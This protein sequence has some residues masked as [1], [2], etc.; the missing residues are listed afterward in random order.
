MF[1][2]IQTRLMFYLVPFSIVTT[3][4]LVAILIYGQYSLF[5]EELNKSLYR[6]SILAENTITKLCIANDKSLEDINFQFLND[7]PDIEYSIISKNRTI[8]GDAIP[9][10]Y[11]LDFNKDNIIQETYKNNLYYRTFIKKF[12]S[13][14]LSNYYLLL[15]VSD[16]KMTANKN[17]VI[18]LTTILL[19][20][21]YIFVWM[22]SKRITF[23]IQRPVKKLSTLAKDMAQGELNTE[24]KMDT[25]DE[26][27]DIANSF[28]SM[29][30]DLKSIMTEV[31]IKS[32]QTAEIS[33]I[34]GYVE[35]ALN[36]MPSG[37]IGVDNSGQI[38]VFNETA[39]RITSINSNDILGKNIANPMPVGIENLITPLK[40]CLLLGR[41]KLKTITEI[42]NPLKKKITV[43]YNTT[44]Q[45]DQN[46]KVIGALI[47]FKRIE[48]IERFEKSAEQ[49][50]SLRYLGEISASLAH[51]MR[52]PLTSI[53]GYT[54]YLQMML[55]DRKDLQEELN[56]ITNETDR[57]DVMLSNFLRFAKPDIPKKESSDLNALISYVL[58]FMKA[59]IP[60]NITIKEDYNEIPKVMID[61]S[62][63]E[64]VFINLFINAIHAMPDGGTLNIK[65]HYSNKRKMVIVE[66]SDTGIGIPQD[67]ADKIF[68]PFSTTKSDGTGL[69]LAICN[70]II[71]AH[72]GIIEVESQEGKGAKFT[73]LLRGS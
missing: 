23:A 44:I 29:Q 47:L 54:Q 16:A 42:Y 46:K 43:L 64:S 32:G 10:K 66:V 56:T 39:Q 53:K 15:E 8:L 51:E 35:N 49:N 55:T 67:F 9:S 14:Q 41:I 38:T 58:N 24:I 60:D 19:I 63:F 30:N 40:S 5:N 27:S 45:F 52:N 50:R 25:N 26:L 2:S 72:N 62:Q 6:H 73:I 12:S 59:E 1:K 37:I 70:R 13:P 68:M 11:N 57:L 20:I 4:V 17:N 61:L 48:D 31:L 36:H 28:N 7:D 71:D 22:L 34:M 33:E 18:T 65:T 21:T 69:G 3:I